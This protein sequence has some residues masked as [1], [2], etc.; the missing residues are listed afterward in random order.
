MPV[1]PIVILLVIVPT[2]PVSNPNPIGAPSQAVLSPTILAPSLSTSSVNIILDFQVAS[3]WYTWVLNKRIS[4]SLM[5]SLD[6][7]PVVPI[8][9][10]PLKYPTAEQTAV[11]P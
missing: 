4:P 3:H 2:P 7:G 8:P 10:H 1:L 5:V 9:T 6:W 11:L